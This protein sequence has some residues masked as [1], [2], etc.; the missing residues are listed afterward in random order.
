MEKQKHPG[1]PIMNLSLLTNPRLGGFDT[2][3]IEKEM[4]NAKS[5]MQGAKKKNKC[6]ACCH[7]FCV[8][9]YYVFYVCAASKQTELQINEITQRN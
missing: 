2:L 7:V 1:H 3:L 6:S 5:Q 8:F 9:V 4:H